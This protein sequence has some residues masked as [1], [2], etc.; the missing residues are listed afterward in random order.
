[1]ELKPFN[2][3][4]ALIEPGSYKTKIFTDNARYARD[5]HKDTSPYYALSQRLKTFLE[6]YVRNT[7]RDP[8]EVAGVIER[9]ATCARPRF[10]NIIGLQGKCRAWIVR[11]LPFEFYSWLITRLLYRREKQDA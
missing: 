5:F 9:V 7:R 6:Q 4:V 2:I 1:M 10:R 8:E 3:D 11:H